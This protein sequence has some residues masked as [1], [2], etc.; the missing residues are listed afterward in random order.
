MKN[1]FELKNARR[2]R[3]EY[4]LFENNW[5]AAQPGYA[6]LFTPRNQD[7]GCPWCVVETVQFS[8]N[9]IRNVTAGVNILGYDTGQRERCRPTGSRITDNLFSA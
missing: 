7:G 2:V 8:H 1:I 5:Q 6:I 3:V 9:I 4:N